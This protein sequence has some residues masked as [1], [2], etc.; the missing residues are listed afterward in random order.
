MF[1]VGN[2]ERVETKPCAIIAIITGKTLAFRPPRYLI[3]A[4]AASDS[5]MIT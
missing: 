4:G 2:D 1:G 5:E 3:F